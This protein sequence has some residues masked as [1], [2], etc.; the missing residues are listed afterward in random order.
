MRYGKHFTYRQL[1]DEVPGRMDGVY[2]LMVF[3]LGATLA[4]LILTVLSV[5]SVL[6]IGGGCSLALLY[7]MSGLI[8]LWRVRREVQWLEKLILLT[9][10]DIQ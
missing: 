4:S 8:L 5:L 7:G 6:Y 3:G 1:W 2:P 10:G 9:K